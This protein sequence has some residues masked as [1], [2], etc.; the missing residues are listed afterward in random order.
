[1]RGSSP[2]SVVLVFTRRIRLNCR[3]A[4]VPM[5]CNGTR[6]P[7]GSANQIAF[8]RYTDHLMQIRRLNPTDSEAFRTLRLSGLQEAASAF[9]SSYEEEV[10]FPQSVTESRLA[11]KPD[12]GLFGAFEAGE[13]V[14]LIALGRE[15]MRKLSHKAYIWGM[16][17]ALSARGRGIGRALLLEALAFARSVTGI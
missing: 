15:S 3:P 7:F 8:P 9:G 6:K 14:G 12:S 5:Q 11:E 17:V 13:L 16:Y 10:A 4:E 1:M 2:C